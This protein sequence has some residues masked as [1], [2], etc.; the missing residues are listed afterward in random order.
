VAEPR[1]PIP[2]R[3]LLLTLAA[4]ILVLLAAVTVAVLAYVNPDVPPL[5]LPTASN[6]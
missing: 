4:A 1:R 6:R 2:D 5:S 3:I